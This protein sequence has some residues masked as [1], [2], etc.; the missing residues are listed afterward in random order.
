MLLQEF[1]PSTFSDTMFLQQLV[2][3]KRSCTLVVRGSSS[4]AQLK[5]LN[6]PLIRRFLD[7]SYSFLSISRTKLLFVTLLILHHPPFGKATRS[8][9]VF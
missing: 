9:Y 1:C 6:V 7:L 5:A 8:F 2:V 4:G 3:V